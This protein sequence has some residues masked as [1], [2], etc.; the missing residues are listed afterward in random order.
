MTSTDIKI[1]LATGV[2]AALAALALRS[3]RRNIEVATSSRR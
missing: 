2:V 1:A 3:W